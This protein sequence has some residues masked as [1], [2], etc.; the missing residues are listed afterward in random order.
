M[1][2]CTYKYPYRCISQLSIC[3]EVQS[4]D[5]KM[6]NYALYTVQMKPGEVQMVYVT[7]F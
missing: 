6:Y 4:G 2:R 7:R 5:L 3:A 1:K